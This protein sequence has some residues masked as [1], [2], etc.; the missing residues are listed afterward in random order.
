MLLCNLDV[1]KGL[2]NGARGVVVG[3]ADSKDCV[4]EG[5]DYHN[6]GRINIRKQDGFE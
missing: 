2:G 6:R 1:S 4:Q 5:H 3:F